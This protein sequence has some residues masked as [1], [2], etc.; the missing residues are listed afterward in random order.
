M[1]LGDIEL[2]VMRWCPKGHD[3]RIGKAEDL[4]LAMT[5]GIVNGESRLGGCWQTYDYRN[6]GTVLLQS[7]GLS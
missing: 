5:G 3:G 7:T 6:A 4:E 2:R 1:V